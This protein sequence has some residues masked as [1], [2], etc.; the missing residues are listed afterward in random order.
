MTPELSVQLQGGL[1]QRSYRQQA[2][3]VDARL[4]PVGGFALEVDPLP[5]WRLRPFLRLVVCY[6]L[7]RTELVD[8]RGVKSTLPP[9]QF[10][11]LVGMRLATRRWRDRKMFATQ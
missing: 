5:D 2:N 8:E 4:R 3:P 1:A 11:A 7:V 6:D 10:A 9:E